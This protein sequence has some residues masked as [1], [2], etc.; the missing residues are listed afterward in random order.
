MAAKIRLIK[1]NGNQNTYKSHPFHPS[2][3]IPRVQEREEKEWARRQRRSGLP[4]LMGGAGGG[5]PWVL[6]AEG[7]G[8]VKAPRLPW[9]CGHLRM[10]DMRP[11]G[12]S[13]K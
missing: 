8:K 6:A 1:T 12:V 13:R 2:V 9:I 5:V 4:D 7:A 3:G 11:Q 10:L